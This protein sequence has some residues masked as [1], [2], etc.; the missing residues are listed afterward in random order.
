MPALLWVV[1][2]S[3]VA[4][5]LL[6]ALTW[7][8]PRPHPLPTARFVP[9][10][11][12]ASR[13]RRMEFSELG[14]M[15]L[16]LLSLGLLG[17]A[18]AGTVGTWRRA[19]FGRVVV[20]DQSRAVGSVTEVADSLAPLMREGATTRLVVFDSVPRVVTGTPTLGDASLGTRRGNLAAALIVAVREGL[21][22]RATVDSVDLVI[23]SP[24]VREEV[25]GAVGA[26]VG[27]W[28]GPVRLVRVS[29]REAVVNAGAG[30]RL[31]VPND[32]LGAAAW[33]AWGSSRPDL[34]LQR[35]APSPADSAFA[36][37]GGTLVVWPTL[38]H[39]APELGAASTG[40]VATIGRFR[41]AQ[42]SVRGSPVAWREDG[43]VVAGE[44]LAGLGCLRTV[45]VDVP[46][47]G[48]AALRPA[49]VAFVR[50][51]TRRCG[52]WDLHVMDTSVLAPLQLAGTTAQVPE[53]QRSAWVQRLLLLL[54][55]VSL[56]VEGW[57]RDRRRRAG[58]PTS[59][60]PAAE[61][62]A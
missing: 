36:R 51:L 12:R 24:L 48:D 47:P 5:V 16:R 60:A 14:I 8:R 11:S 22:L 35:A 32:P 50:D 57:L 40:T 19:S 54:A 43:R 42:D 41:W 21:R 13:L 34:R 28:G 58:P 7:R 15:A 18:A 20:V 17:I 10:A 30:G 39:D 9:V 52:G 45:R 33:T 29:A 3:A 1:A 44:E 4:V 56:G 59:V 38:T 37:A 27:A 55:L 31:P 26:I 49:F 25:N 61:D 46:P 2:V 6:H 23:V 62:A 53:G